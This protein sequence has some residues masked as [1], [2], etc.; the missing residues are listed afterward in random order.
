MLGV[1]ANPAT[2]AVVANLG[3]SI[4][5][6]DKREQVT[7]ITACVFIDRVLLLVA[8]LQQTCVTSYQRRLM[9]V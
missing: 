7:A 8:F 9:L 6:E 1:F 4:G 3:L 2:L 5:G